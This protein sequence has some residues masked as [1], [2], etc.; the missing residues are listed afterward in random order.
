MF[1]AILSLPTGKALGLNGYTVEFYKVFWPQIEPLF[2][3][4]ITDFFL[5]GTLPEILKIAAISLTHKKDKDVYES[6]SFCP[7]SLLLVDFKIISKLIAH[8]FENLL[9][10]FINP[11]Q[12]GFVKTRNA[13]DNVR[14]LLNII[15]HSA[16]YKQPALIISLDAEKAFD[17]VEWQYLFSVLK[18][19]NVGNRCLRCIKSMYSNP[20]AQIC[21]NGTLSEKFGLHR[22]CRQGCPLSSF[23][24]NLAIEPFAEDAQLSSEISG[25]CIDKIENRISL[26]ADDI[27][28][29]LNNP[30]NSIPATLDLINIFGRISMHS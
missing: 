23:L 8:R 15:D 7:I 5:N 4:M 14:H 1:Q 13:F 30:D 28:L 2:M 3:S 9:P 16:L 17:R 25:I 29:Y 10:Q 22:G 12:S 6:S 20:H 11:D 26:Y 21:V 27:I 24:F 19:F 18:K